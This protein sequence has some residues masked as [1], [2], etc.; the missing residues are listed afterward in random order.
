MEKKKINLSVIPYEYECPV[1][2]YV[3]KCG[4]DGV[5][6]WGI[7]NDYPYYLLSLMEKSGKH[8]AIVKTKSQ[9][10]GGNGFNESNM[11]KKALNFISNPYGEE[12]LDSILAKVSYDLEIYGGYAL[13]VI[14]S[15][16]RESV[17][18]IKYIDISKISISKDKEGNIEY[19]Y[20]QETRNKRSGAVRYKPFNPD[21]REEASTI[22][23][24]AE[25]R[26]GMGYYP[27]PE[28]IS[29]ANWME[30]EYEIS[31][32]HLKN[33]KNGF[34]P[35]FSI[36]VNTGI[37]SPEERDDF[38]TYIK[39]QFEG[40]INAGKAFVT[41]AEDKDHSVDIT[42]IE[43]NDNDEKFITLN[44]ST[45]DGIFQAHRITNPALFGVLT[46]GKLGNTQELAEELK[47]FN[48]LYVVPKQM[49][50]ERVFN[51]FSSLSGV[52]DWLK[53]NTYEIKIAVVPTTNDILLILNSP[54]SSEA[55]R[56]LL[57]HIG[58]PQDKAEILVPIQENNNPTNG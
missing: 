50:L 36:A 27:I 34:A 41:F 4:R 16:D 52:N 40:S 43:T 32:F 47:R 9:L 6:N 17:A 20:S 46:P 38:Y 54:V 5:I 15:R 26:P 37:P 7:S 55:K 14:W 42:P 57:L 2:V 31:Q 3:E 21:D 8:S 35:S 11:S 12:S 22:F 25:Y 13:N 28:Y 56:E 48:D 49:A 10:I 30:L 24:Y 33:V 58:L 29:G 39:K 18:A 45:E 19:I 44:E 51:E 23:F 1:P 53:I